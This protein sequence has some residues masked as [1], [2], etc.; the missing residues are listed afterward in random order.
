[1]KKKDERKARLM[2]SRES[3]D[4]AADVDTRRRGLLGQATTL[5]PGRALPPDEQEVEMLDDDDGF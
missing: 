4:H 3:V 2:K 5:L 1:M